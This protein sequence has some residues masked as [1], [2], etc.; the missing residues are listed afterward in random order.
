MARMKNRMRATLRIETTQVVTR[1]ESSETQIRSPVQKI[2]MRP[3]VKDRQIAVLL[4]FL[5]N[6]RMIM[7]M[8]RK[9]YAVNVSTRAR[10][11]GNLNRL[12]FGYNSGSH[13]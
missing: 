4:R 8:L 3:I 2:M 7:K 5:M 9:T 6:K 12:E 13:C 11:G 10:A 1:P